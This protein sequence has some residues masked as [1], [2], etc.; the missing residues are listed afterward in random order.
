MA[1]A[2]ERAWKN[3]YEELQ[4]RE[5]ENNIYKIARSRAGKKRDIDQL[6]VVKSER[7]RIL[8]VEE[9]FKARLKRY[10]QELLNVENERGHLEEMMP[11]EGP[12]QGV[13][14]GEVKKVLEAFKA[15][16]AVGPPGVSAE[17]LKSLDE[18]RVKWIT[19]VVRKVM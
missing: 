5:G 3:W 12:V 8:V 14:V 16:K 7:G 19:E 13:S 17:Q 18:E 11:V 10:F 2:K 6:A 4:T 15:G 9:E 1:R